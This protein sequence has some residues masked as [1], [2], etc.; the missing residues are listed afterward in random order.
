MAAETPQ[1]E[2]A[3]ARMAANSSSTC[4]AV[5]IQQQ[6]YQITETTKTAWTMPYAPACM[7][8]PRIP[9]PRITRP[10]LM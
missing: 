3:E 6:R 1:I 2:T 4:E 10:V 9:A 7:I 8:S 5:A